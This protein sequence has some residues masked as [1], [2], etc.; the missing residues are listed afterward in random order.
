[1]E[2]L[3][4]VI[5]ILE[6]AESGEEFFLQCGIRGIM[7]DTPVFLCWI[8]DKFYHYLSADHALLLFKYYLERSRKYDPV[9]FS[10]KFVK[11][12]MLKDVLD[13]MTYR[14][15]G[16]AEFLKFKTV[17][18]ML[19]CVRP[20]FLHKMMGA[21]DDDELVTKIGVICKERTYERC[22]SLKD[23]ISC[24]GGNGMDVDSR[25]EELSENGLME[26]KNFIADFES[27]LAEPSIRKMNEAE[28]DM[29]KEIENEEVDQDDL[30]S[31]S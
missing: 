15:Y 12:I 22:Q 17:Y 25:V 9:V 27:M 26:F 28:K 4:Q 23:A 30:T 16:I 18:R 13:S 20:C 19:D 10:E 1:M 21:K 2:D 3:L 8:L 31:R 14:S 11:D 24:I 29:E 6:E 7:A 5:R